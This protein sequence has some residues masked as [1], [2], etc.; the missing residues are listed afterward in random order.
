MNVEVEVV[1]QDAAQYI[2]GNVVSCMAEMSLIVDRGTTRIPG[3]FLSF[4]RDERFF[5][6]SERVVYF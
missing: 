4:S 1:S 5:G 6:S 2:D 3:D